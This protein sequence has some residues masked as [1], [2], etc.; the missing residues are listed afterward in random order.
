[1]RTLSV[2]LALCAA[3]GAQST[4]G[5]ELGGDDDDAPPP[6][7]SGQQVDIDAAPSPDAA[8]SFLAQCIAKGYTAQTGLGSLYR[9]VG[10]AAQFDAA[11]SACAGDVAGATHLVVLTDDVEVAFI[12]TKLGW[13][14]LSD[15]KTEGTFVN[16]T[17]ETP[18]KRPFLSGQPDNGSGS[19]DCV[20]MKSGGL[21]DDQCDNQHA[22]V[23]ECDGRPD[24]P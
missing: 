8:P 3:C 21:D 15:Q 10:T 17:Q 7:A 6:D 11:R 24:T 5:G 2:A 1:M 18:D 12:K 16:V 13:V 19:E 23:C 9:V 14:G 20:Q 4:L 22:Y